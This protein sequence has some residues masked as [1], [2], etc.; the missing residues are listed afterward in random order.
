VLV[1]RPYC[2]GPAVTVSTLRDGS[3]N[4]ALCVKKGGEETP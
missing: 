1:F 3:P 4:S 2:K